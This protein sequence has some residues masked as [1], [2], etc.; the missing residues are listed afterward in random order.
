MDYSSPV[1]L[2]SPTPDS[3][4]INLE[5]STASITMA[6]D[7]NF[8][9]N[10]GF[11]AVVPVAVILMVILVLGA[12]RAQSQWRRGGRF[13]PLWR[14]VSGRGSHSDASSPAGRSPTFGRPFYSISCRRCITLVTCTTIY[15]QKNDF[16]KTII[17]VMVN[18]SSLLA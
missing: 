15:L 5:A 12:F 9:A 6:A 11:L 16:H 8:N 18:R 7:D 17:I 4:S 13:C 14:R 1:F 3:I 10:A 2:P